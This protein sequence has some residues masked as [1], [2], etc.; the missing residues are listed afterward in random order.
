[1]SSERVSRRFFLSASIAAGGGLLIGYSLS[2][3]SVVGDVVLASS[4][5]KAISGSDIPLNA[6]I[7]ISPNDEVTLISSQSEMGQGIMTTLP[8]VLAEELGADW[9]R[10]KIE[11]SSVAPAYRNPR[12]NWQFTGNSESTTGFFELMRTMGASAREML[13]TAAANRWGV[14]AEECHAENG[15]IIHKATRRAFKFGDLAEE[16]ANIPPPQNPKPKPQ[17]EWKLLGRPLPRVELGSKVNGTAIF[18][19]DFTVPGMV[20]AA[21]MQSPVHGGTVSS[22]DKASVM[23]LAGV[24]DVV[25]IPNG[26]AVVANQYWQARQALKSLKVNFISGAN[27]DLSSD[28][29]MRQYRSALEGNSWKTVRTEGDALGEKVIASK[30]Q[31]VFSQDYESQF[32]AHATMEPMNCTAHVIDDSCTVWGPL[33]GPELAKVTLSGMLKL[34]PEKVSINRTLL[35]GGFGR[36]L[37]VDFVVQAALISKAVAKPVK[38]VWSREEDIQHD[39]YRPAT[40]NRITAGLDKSGRPVALAHKVVSPSILQFVYAPAVTEDNDPSCLEGLMESHYEIPSQRVDF[41]LLKV[42]V[43]TSVLRT[44]GYGP[45]IFTVESFIDELAAKAKQDPYDFRHGLLKDQRSLKVLEV[46]ADK[47]DWKRRLPKDVARGMAYTEA[48]RTHIAHAVELSVKDNLVKIHRIVCVIDCGIALDP[49]ITKNSIEGGTVWGLGVT[50]KSKISFKEGRTVESN[51][52]DYQ[53]AQ[54]DETPPIEVH[55]VNSSAK[56]LGG[57]GEVGPVT[58]APAVT[59][60]IFAA[61][62]RRFRSLPLSRHGLKLAAYS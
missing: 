24:I 7:R 4:Q 33:Q 46:L 32:M 25:P 14:K 58:I 40:L 21:A 57:T 49:E 3:S 16:A 41:K 55:I 62:G 26:V 8:A 2:S 23:N 56:G 29:L 44:T 52:H 31:D 42:G 27:S 20:Y 10:V 48:F 53:I 35:G 11:F 37:L 22:F 59:N 18:G 38:V 39:V 5:G 36:R 28:S 34:P 30:H 12:I 1:M 54:M 13:L 6:W 50:F 43:P 19:L 9:K 60:A 45:N 17:D 61:T 47:S 15:K 51:F